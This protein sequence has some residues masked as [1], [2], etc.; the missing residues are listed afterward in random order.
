MIS[1]NSLWVNGCQKSTTE[2][3]WGQK[4]KLS[5]RAMTNYLANKMHAVTNLINNRAH[6]D[7]T[8]KLILFN[9]HPFS[10]RQHQIHYTISSFIN[11]QICYIHG[12]KEQQAT[13][14]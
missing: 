11:E 9:F 7:E 10:L 12:M 1:L 8:R 3:Q 14:E 2:L 13:I 5:G 4:L 6:A